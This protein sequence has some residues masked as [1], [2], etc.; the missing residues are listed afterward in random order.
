MTTRATRGRDST[1]YF[2]GTRV[3]AYL[4][5][6]ESEA[7]A[8]DLE[9]TPFESADKEY[10]TGTSENTTTLTGTFNGGSGSLDEL[11]DTAYATGSTDNQLLIC[12]GGVMTAG[13]A[14]LMLGDASVQKQKVSG[15]SDDI[16]EFEA[17]LRSKRQRALI[18]KTPVAVS[19]TGN[20]S[21]FQA[22]A[23]TSYGA[24]ATIYLE[25]VGGTVAPTGINFEIEHSS[26]GSSYSTFGVAIASSLTSTDVGRAIRYESDNTLTLEKYVRVKHTITG[27]TAPSVKYVAALHRRL[28]TY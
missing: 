23:A 8:D 1:I 15:K 27:G 13:K 19:A 17:E 4:D 24:I 28:G 25:S 11:L 3:S 26:D 18:L 22:S 2:N 10:L 14:G 7:E 12:P 21:A 16:N 9:F 5:E 6:Y 20:G